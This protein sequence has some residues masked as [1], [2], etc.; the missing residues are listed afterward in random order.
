M[1]HPSNVS[2]YLEETTVK[3]IFFCKTSGIPRPSISWLKNN[4]TLIG[5]M[6]IQNGSTST[7]LIQ[8]VTK[9]EDFAR[10]K[11]IA[12]NPCGGVSSQ[13]GVLVVREQTQDSSARLVCILSGYVFKKSF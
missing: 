5:G 3:T 2:L 1:V 4:S 9:V 7:L 11:C 6:A 8:R 13:E 12:K 10:F